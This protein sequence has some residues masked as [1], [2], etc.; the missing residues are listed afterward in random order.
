MYSFTHSNICNTYIM[1]YI[2]IY[3]PESWTAMAKEN[4][5]FKNV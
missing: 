1:I 4:V 5:Y 2:Y 3:V